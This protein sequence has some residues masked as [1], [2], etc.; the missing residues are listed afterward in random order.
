VAVNF[1]S[2]EIPLPSFKKSVFKKWIKQVAVNE[3]CKLGEVSVIFVSDAYLLNI[4]NQYLNHNYHTDIITFDYSV[5]DAKCKTIGGD[6]FI[7]VDTLETNS[8]IYN[9][10]FYKELCRVV[11]HGILHLIGYKDKTEEEFEAMKL[12]EEECLL[13]LE[14]MV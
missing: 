5:D 10:T 11:I 2:E 13:L 4:N 9:V 7:S 8:K 6:L 14:S 3:G 1:Y 12:K